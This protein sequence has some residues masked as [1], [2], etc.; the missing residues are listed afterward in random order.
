MNRS[1]LRLPV[2]A[3][4]LVMLAACA[5][6]TT[7]TA[8]QRNGAAGQRQRAVSAGD[9]GSY[10]AA[11]VGNP[12]HQPAFCRCHEPPATEEASPEA[13]GTPPPT[14]VIVANS[15]LPA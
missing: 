10:R 7:P 9:S 14:P 13:S 3:V 15:Q 5:G 4:I 11:R 8:P 2:W 6:N 1:W 12:R